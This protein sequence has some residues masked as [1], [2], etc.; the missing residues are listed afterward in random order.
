MIEGMFAE[1]VSACAGTAVQTAWALYLG[2]SPLLV[3][4]LGALPFS[5]LLVHL[6]AAWIS[7]RFGCRRT[8]LLS[9]GISRQVMLPL[10]VLPFLGASAATRQAIFLASA[11]IAAVLGVFGNNAWSTWMSELCPAGVRGAY[12]GRRSGLCALG[13]TVS[14]LAV[15]LALDRRPQAPAVALCGLAIATSLVGL[16]TTL[17]L[18]RQRD[19][20]PVAP[21]P[22]TLREAL[23]PLR[24]G[25][26]RRLLTFQLAWSATT[27]LAA[28]F[29]PLYMI[30]TLHMGFAR[31]ALYNA[32]LAAARMLAA[33]LWGRAQDRLGARP[34]LIV[35][36]FGLALSPALWLLPS[37]HNLWP[38]AVDAV[39]GG[40]LLGGY[41]LAAFTLP[42][43]LSGPRE[44]S[45]HVAAFAAT[46]GLAMGLAS[47]GGGAIVHALP[48]LTFGFHAPQILFALA[49]LSRLLAAVLSLRIVEVG[50]RPVR[51]LGSLVLRRPPERRTKLAA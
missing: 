32:G 29:Y 48:P 8:A 42:L 35:C 24:S 46:G 16:F 37:E 14:S 3:G 7:R 2:L 36:S 5:A 17:L 41:N 15:G 38:L 27:G 47:L 34:L 9:I 1:L 25:R 44:R 19:V 33:P 50:S 49:A 43:E 12:F 40:A 51:E 6:P 30:G 13:A 39:L 22:P 45:F 18:A 26:A 28:A 11:A 23:S 10:A 31:M 4:L 21:A 20:H